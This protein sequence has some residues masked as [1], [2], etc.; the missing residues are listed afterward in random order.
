MKKIKDYNIWLILVLAL[1]LRLVNLNQSFWLDEAAQVIE[2]SRPLLNQFDIAADF[3]PPL[4]H[5]LLHFWMY[6][7]NSE[8]W[9]RILPVLLGI[10]SIYVTYKLATKLGGRTIGLYT[11]LFLALSPYH[12]WYSQETRPYMLFVFLSIASSLLLLSKKWSLYLVSVFLCLYSLYM[13]PFLIFSHFLYVYLFDK[14]SLRKFILSM[15]IASLTF[16]PWLPRFLKQLTVGTGGFF[17]GWTEIVS[18]Q[19]PKVIPL[20]FAKFIFGRGSIENNL[21][22]TLVVLPTF[23]VFFLSF[24]KIW[25]KKEGKILLILFSIPFAL[26]VFTSLFVPIAAP[27]R[28]IFLLPIFYVVIAFYLKNIKSTFKYIAIV[29][30]ILTSLSGLIDY[31]ANP[32]TQREQWRQAVSKVEENVKGK[33]VSLFVFPT[34]FAPYLWYQKERLDAIGI[35]PDFSLN[36]QDLIVLKDKITGKD[37]IFLFQYLTGLTDPQQ[38]T[39]N[40]LKSSGMTESEIYDFPGVGFIF[41]Y[42]Q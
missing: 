34:P 11:A 41:V 4:F 6:A 1:L 5:I 23:L 14:K 29:V 3:H 39:R 38:R 25:D 35:A 26:V 7:G 17:T 16:L 37:R 9:V 30:I 36:D 31:F 8:I 15:G 21:I 40:F 2:S 27:Q 42:D 24:I 12:V 22:Y 33:S 28:L 32:Y 18:I 19:T 13:A 10:G 20:T